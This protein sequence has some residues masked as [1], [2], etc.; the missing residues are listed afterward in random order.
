MKLK[1]EDMSSINFKAPWYMRLHLA[2]EMLLFGTFSLQGWITDIK[3]PE[4]D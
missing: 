1:K 2:V 3:E 4:A